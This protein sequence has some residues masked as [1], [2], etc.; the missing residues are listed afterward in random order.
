MLFDLLCLI[1]L[2]ISVAILSATIIIAHKRAKIKLSQGMVVT[3]MYVLLLGFFFTALVVIAPIV[4]VQSY[5]QDMLFGRIIKSAIASIVCAAKAYGFGNE[6]DL[7]D[8]VVMNQALVNPIIGNIY[9][10]YV[11]L[12]FFGMP[13]LSAGFVLSFFKNVS[14][15]IK[16]F[17]VRE[18]EIYYLSELNERSVALAKNILCMAG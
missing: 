18:G 12:L 3:P 2:A 1:S 15:H 5:T 7:I 6:I 4:Y 17:L 8:N 11:S 14:A 10:V 16:Y 9:S 13:F